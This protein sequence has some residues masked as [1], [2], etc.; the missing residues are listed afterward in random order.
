MC[1]C[2]LIHS[3]NKRG[4]SDQSPQWPV[5]KQAELYTAI[6][7]MWHSSPV[8]LATTPQLCGR[9]NLSVSVNSSLGS[10]LHAKMPQSHPHNPRHPI[11][12]CCV[13]SAAM[14]SRCGLA[15]LQSRC[16][17]W[18]E[19]SLETPPTSGPNESSSDCSER[20][21]SWVC[22]CADFRSAGGV[23]YWLCTSV[24]GWETVSASCMCMCYL[25]NMLWISEQVRQ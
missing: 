3:D 19:G 10:V 24:E 18:F 7:D 20:F 2:L 5:R 4:S 13:A 21:Q 14:S 16:W 25:L 8:I 22:I 17:M 12:L 9:R 15:P 6:T 23:Q 1:F 11:S